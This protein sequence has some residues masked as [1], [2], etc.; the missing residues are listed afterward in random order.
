MVF[1]D[2]QHR[3]ITLKLVYYGPALS[4]KTTNLQQLHALMGDHAGTGLMTLNTRDDRTLF[5]DLLPLTM[6]TGSGM[7]IKL[8]LFTVPGQVFHAATRR[9]VLQGA[10][11][12]VFVADSRISETRA[13]NE[14]FADLKANLADNGIG[15]GDI[16]VAIQFNKRD[17]PGIRSD[18]DVRRIAAKGDEPVF[19]AIAIEGVGV[20]ETFLGIAASTWQKLERRYELARRFGVGEDEFMAHLETSLRRPGDP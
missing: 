2:I 7:S 17:L 15:W 19:T 3:E 4:G 16:A 1:I 13:N 18:D 6:A 11:G 10:D 14:S 5:F 20:A 12:V 9:I 8:K